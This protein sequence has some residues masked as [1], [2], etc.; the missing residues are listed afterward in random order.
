MIPQCYFCKHFDKKG[1]LSCKAFKEIPVK[2]L[3]N[4]ELHTV[5]TEKTGYVFEPENK[6]EFE[7]IKHLLTEMKGDYGGE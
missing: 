6:K 3:W 1:K 7:K 4:R 5:D 2:Y